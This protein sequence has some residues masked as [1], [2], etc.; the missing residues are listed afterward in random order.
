MRDGRAAAVAMI[1]LT[2]VLLAALP[3]WRMSDAPPPD[4]YAETPESFVARAEAQIPGED[5]LLVARRFAFGPAVELE[6]GR[7]YRLH[8]TSAD[9]VHSLVLDG[10]ELL[11]VPGQVQVLT[12]TPTGPLDIRC[13]EY[14]GL[15]HNTMRTTVTVRRPPSSGTAPPPARP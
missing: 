9:T 11:L 10:R 12:I 2:L 1:A 5:V 7:T 3:A 13:N 6:A 14:C 15:G 4:S 8:V